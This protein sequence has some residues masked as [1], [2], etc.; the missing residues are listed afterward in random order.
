MSSLPELPDHSHYT[1][2]VSWS[3]EDQEHIG[4]CAEFP[5]LSWLEPEPAAAFTGI[6]N[7]VH[8]VIE[9][10]AENNEPIPQPLSERTYSGKFMVRVPPELHAQLV[11][12][13]AEQG[14]SLNLLANQRLALSP[15]TRLAR[16]R[17][18]FDSV[19]PNAALNRVFWSRRGIGTFYDPDLGLQHS[20]LKILKAAS[21]ENGKMV[22]SSEPVAAGE[23]DDQQ[24]PSTVD[25]PVRQA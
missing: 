7:L 21:D 23:D 25:V 15:P 18:A 1:Y 9:D 8:E 6:M 4:L 17:P 24:V 16:P 10:L 3:A 19:W 13:A 22:R 5:S 2:R 11:R 12:E 20:V 14:V